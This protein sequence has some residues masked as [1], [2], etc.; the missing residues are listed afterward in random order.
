MSMVNF[1]RLAA[2]PVT[3]AIDLDGTI[4]NYTNHTV[5]GEPIPQNVELMRKM[6][7]LGWTIVVFTARL[8][9]PDGDKK[10]K[11]EEYLRSKGVPFDEVTNIKPWKASLFLDD[12]GMHVAKNQAWDP[13]II[14]LIK[15]QLGEQ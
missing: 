12:R 11:I 13:N 3:V 2:H 6:K 1:K 10:E 15:R 7:A 4:L 9:A 8:S 14:E 5:L